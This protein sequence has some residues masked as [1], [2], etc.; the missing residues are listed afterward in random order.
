MKIDKIF[1][2]WVLDSRGHPTVACKSF[3]GEFSAIAMV[4]SG[5]ST[6]SREA[7][8][9]RDHNGKFFGYG[10]EKAVD[11]INKILAP[12]ISKLELINLQD[13]D[14]RMIGMDKTDN[15]SI[16]GANAILAVS[17]SLARLGA[18][19]TKT[20]LFEYLAKMYS[21]RLN[22]TMP[23]PYMNIVNGGAHAKNG[24]DFQEFMIVPNGAHTFSDAIRMGAEVYMKL[25]AI[26]KSTG[27]GDEGGY[28]PD[29]FQSELDIDKIRE[30]LDDI[31]TSI[32]QAGYK[33]GTDIS[34]AID[35]AAGVFYNSG[36]YVLK[37]KEIISSDQLIKLYTELAAGYPIISIEDGLSDTDY[38]GWK[39][40]NDAL[41]KNVDIVGDDLFTTNVKYLQ[42][43]IDEKLA[44]S[45]IV[46]INQ[47]GTITETVAFIKLAQD[48]NI[49]TVIS[50]R[51]GETEDTSISDIALAFN[52]GCIKAG[53]LAR[54]ERTAK[55]NRLLEIEY[56]LGG[57][58]LYGK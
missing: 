13:I 2:Y 51:S 18:Q 46:K 48:N 38:S 39:K 7:L 17:L 1:A 23:V 58:A 52:A 20:P 32:Q 27:V 25:G 24:L 3:A 34:I 55:Y 43:G 40:L 41:G 33:P 53:S 45:A 31:K 12:E 50:H 42:K 21:F 22:Y 6:G 49:K 15:K 11:N 30:V 9:L 10:V 8:E 28:S 16:L 26:I 4:P 5:A 19:V 29:R 47:I 54:S 36:R 35:V 37:D 56:E 14:N 44:N 57:K